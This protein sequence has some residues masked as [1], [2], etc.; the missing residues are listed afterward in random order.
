M[1][2]LLCSYDAKES[3][4][5]LEMSVNRGETPYQRLRRN[6]KNFLSKASVII[7]TAAASAGKGHLR[8]G[9]P[10]SCPQNE[11]NA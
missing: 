1:E 4:A 11:M 2:I 8:G 9:C 7:N 6:G 10:S 3:I 5:Y